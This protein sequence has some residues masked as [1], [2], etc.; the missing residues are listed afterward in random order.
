MFVVPNTW[1]S[2]PLS[3]ASLHLDNKWIFAQ[4]I[5]QFQFTIVVTTLYLQ[6]VKMSGSPEK[7]P[8]TDRQLGL[9]N[10]K[11]AIGRQL[12]YIGVTQ[13]INAS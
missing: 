11:T 8:Q 6:I 5:S 2:E 9:E 4:H 7:E 13:T 12:P 1:R 3:Y 10:R